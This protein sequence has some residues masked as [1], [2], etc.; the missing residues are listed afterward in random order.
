MLLDFHSAINTHIHMIFNVAANI[1][2]IFSRKKRFTYAIFLLT[3]EIIYKHIG[4]INC[5]YSIVANK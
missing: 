3:A 2:V 4:L 1:I 5:T